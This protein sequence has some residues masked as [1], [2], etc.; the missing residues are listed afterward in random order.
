MPAYL[1]PGAED[2]NAGTIAERIAPPAGFER[3]PAAP[4]SF[5]NWLRNLPLRPENTPVRLYDGR[6]RWSQDQHVAVIG[7]DTGDRDLQQ[8]ADAIMR[9]RAEYLLASGQAGRIAFNYTNGKR[10]RY[11]GS[12]SDRKAF[13]RYMTGVFAY[14]GTY[15]LER[16]MAKASLA[17]IRIGDVFINGGFPGHAVLVADMAENARTGEKRFLLVQSY[18]P[19]QDM[20]V[21]KDMSGREQSPWFSVPTPNEPFITP[22]WIFKANSLR[23][24]RD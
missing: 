24:F 22:D 3:V 5:A 6:L 20:H 8:C 13:R 18:M 21:L 17:D 16:E 14:A 1:W 9:L 12:A 10:V 7:I 4:G 19:A 11:R 15:S 23:R 2:Y